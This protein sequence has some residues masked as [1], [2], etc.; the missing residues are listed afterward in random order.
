MDLG[1]QLSCA[2][3]VGLITIGGVRIAWPEPAAVV[4]SR[5]IRVA[6]DFAVSTFSAVVAS[7]GAQIAALPLLLARFHM[8]PWVAPAANLLA[9]PITGL[10]LAAAWIAVFAEAV[11]P[12]LGRPMWNACEALVVALDRVVAGAADLPATGWGVRSDGGIVIVAGAAAALLA[13]AFVPSRGSRHD[14]DLPPRRIAMACTGLAALLAVLL[15]AYRSTPRTPPPGVTW[16]IALDVGQGD[17]IAIAS[18]DEWWLVDTGPSTPRWDAGD[19]AILPFLRWAGLRRLDHL[20]LTHD[21]GDHIGGAPAIL[22]ALP[23]GE[24]VGPRSL[25]WRPVSRDVP[26]RVALRGDTLSARPMLRVLWPGLEE[27]PA[28]ALARS[29]DNA[30]SLVL[31]V[32]Q[33]RARALLLADVDS[34]VEDRLVVEP[35]P[36]LL[37][38]GHHGS[39]SSSGGR[40][41][42]RIEPRTA[43]VSCGRRNAFGHPNAGA[44]QRLRASGASIVRID[45][46]GAL[47]FEMTDDT[48]RRVDW[49]RDRTA[50]R[51]A[52]SGNRYAADRPLR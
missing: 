27:A 35:G 30:R 29:S 39:G 36:V 46:E 52:R 47:W 31:E 13:A 4:R 37:K 41:L 49:R 10:L 22:R 7:V 20:V 43:I 11:M 15:T 17:A 5:P 38:V 2:A 33:R 50:P 44:L 51:E 25:R 24:V 6:R 28:R 21:D 45:E 34:T 8:L 48:V 16:L 42:T 40:F 1:F 23:V 3:T 19:G 18:G 12:G 32:G 26:V 9:V 14:D